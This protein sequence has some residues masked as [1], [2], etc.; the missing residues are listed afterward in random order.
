MVEVSEAGAAQLRFKVVAVA[1]A[2]YLT[3][4]LTGVRTAL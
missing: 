2:G 1:P 3:P 4:A